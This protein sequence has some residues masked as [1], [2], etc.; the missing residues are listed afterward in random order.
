[1]F[2]LKGCRRHRSQVPLADQRI[3][4]EDPDSRRSVLPHRYRDC[5]WMVL[6]ILQG[7]LV[8]NKGDISL[9]T[10]GGTAIYV[11]GRKLMLK[12]EELSAYLRS[13][14]SSKISSIRDFPES[15]RQLWG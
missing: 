12:G 1:M 8:S 7:I 2:P 13:L 15:K 9:A 4:W 5:R 3:Q 11:N 14:P 10:I 6:S